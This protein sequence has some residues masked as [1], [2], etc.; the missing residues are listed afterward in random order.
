MKNDI[1]IVL[2]EAREQIH[3]AML[4][5]TA[6]P[7]GAVTR[8]YRAMLSIVRLF[9]PESQSGSGSHK[10]MIQDFYRGFV[11]PGLV[12]TGFYE[13]LVQVRNVLEQNYDQLESPV[14]V[15]QEQILA[16]ITTASQLVEFCQTSLESTV[17]VKAG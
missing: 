3:E 9:L 10:M 1:D 7:N 5:V 2:V 12:T 13:Q 11:Q 17:K 8:I 15:S 6:D 4:Q 14:A 16:W